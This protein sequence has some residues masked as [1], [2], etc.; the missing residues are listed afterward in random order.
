MCNIHLNFARNWN[1]VIIYFGIN[2]VEVPSKFDVISMVRYLRG[3]SA[4]F[5]LIIHDNCRRISIELEINFP[6]R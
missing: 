6:V 4:L 1:R 5:A 2:S 3:I